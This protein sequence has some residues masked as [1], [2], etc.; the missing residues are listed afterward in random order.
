[1][2]SLLLREKGAVPVALDVKEPVSTHMAILAGTGS[3]KSY[4]AGVLVEELLLPHNRAAV[5]IF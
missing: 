3:G 2:G 1:M 5:L 4:T